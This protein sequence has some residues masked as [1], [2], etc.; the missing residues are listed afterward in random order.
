M[1]LVEALDG[2]Q[3]ELSQPDVT[4]TFTHENVP[5][6]LPPDLT[7][8]LFRIAQEAL[9]NALK[10][11]KARNVSVDLRGVSDG[12]VLTIVDD[13]VGFEV[14]ACMGQRARVDQRP[15]A[16][17]GDWRNIRD[18]LQSWRRDRLEVSV[19]LSILRTTRKR[20]R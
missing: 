9:Q 20:L 4:L 8:C 15:G 5:S 10:H 7:L 2:L 13:G 3:D 17:R 6:T 19:P 1:G 12:I 18:S 11:S 16:S 14:D